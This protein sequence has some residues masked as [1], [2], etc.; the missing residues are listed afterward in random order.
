MELGSDKPGSRY[1][2]Q[3]YCGWQM[4]FFV[5]LQDYFDCL[6]WARRQHLCFYVGCS[7]VSNCESRHSCVVVWRIYLPLVSIRNI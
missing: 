3:R 2:L 4:S 7:I 5:I 6:V 1:Y